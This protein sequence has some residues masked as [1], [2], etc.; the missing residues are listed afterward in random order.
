RRSSGDEDVHAIACEASAERA[1]E[2]NLGA[3]ADDDRLR[4]VAHAGTLQTLRVAARYRALPGD[5]SCRHAVRR[6]TAPGRPADLRATRPP[7]T[8]PACLPPRD[9][10][11]GRRD[12]EEASAGG[13]SPPSRSGCGCPALSRAGSCASRCAA[14]IAS[15]SAMGRADVVQAAV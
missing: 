12:E 5:G 7:A 10:S 1:S 13:P 11:S 2:P 8:V 3:D 6:L 15:A 14:W 4:A 9:S